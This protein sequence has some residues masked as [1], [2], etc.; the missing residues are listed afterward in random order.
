MFLAYYMGYEN[1]SLE[2]YDLFSVY[3]NIFDVDASNFDVH[4]V[5]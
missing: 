2:F 3:G 1:E 5:I 4:H